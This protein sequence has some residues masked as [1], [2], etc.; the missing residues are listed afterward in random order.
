M[1]SVALCTYNGEKY[2]E[3]QIRSIVNQVLPVDEIVVC[4]D[5]SADS[6]VPILNNLQKDYPGILKITSNPAPLGVCGNFQKAISLCRG[7]YIF[8]SDQ[9]DL[10]YPEKTKRIIGWFSDHTD[11]DVVFTNADLID[12]DDRIL[13]GINKLFDTVGFSKNI[14][15]HFDTLAFDIFY[16]A[17]R[18]TGATMAFTK[19][20][21]DSLCINVSATIQNNEPLHDYQIALKA[22][23]NNSIGYICSSL[24]GYRIHSDQVC[25]I[26]G[27]QI[28]PRLDS[29]ITLFND[30]FPKEYLS[31]RQIEDSAIID[32]RHFLLKNRDIKG[33]LRYSHE[34]KRHYG[35]LWV[36]IWLRDCAVSSVSRLKLKH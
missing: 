18:A 33:I 26:G 30:S 11:K 20:F 1:I 19:K 3:R 35:S 2:I 15:R 31:K 6:T 10:W 25:G 14:K 29:H 13:R 24:M 17:N 4:D 28:R 34:Y 16:N 7:D 8:L 5:G 9:D 32:N 22:L 27:L 36:R 21:A 23:D 12:A